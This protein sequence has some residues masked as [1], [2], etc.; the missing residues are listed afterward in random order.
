[1][2]GYLHVF[3]SHLF[4]LMPLEPLNQCMNAGMLQRVMQYLSQHYTENLTLDSLA[5]ALGVSRSH[6]SHLFSA[7]L[8]VNFRR[9]LNT[10]R[11]DQACKLL[12]TTDL[13]ITEISYQC[14]FNDTRTFHRAFLLEQH[15]QP[16]KFRETKQPLK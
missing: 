12:R 16:G 5:H 13:T 2:R 4:T 6:L 10:L 7:Q 9:Y 11:I 14:G 8:K 1:M 3:L 15:V